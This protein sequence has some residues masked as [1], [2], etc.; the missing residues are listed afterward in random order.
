MQIHIDGVAIGDGCPPY[1][2]AEVSANHNQSLDRALEI[3]TKASQAGAS[4]IKIQTYT[5]DTITI[6]SDKEDFQ[7]RGG[8]WGGKTLY[9]LYGEAFTP[10]EWHPQLFTHARQLGITLFSTPFDRTAVDLLEDLNAPAYKIASFESTDI[11]LIQYVASTGKPMII[12]T[13]MA[14][15]EEIGEAV[16]AARGA[17]C[18][19]LVV[20]HCVS[21]YPAPAADYHLRTIADMRQKYQCLVGLSDHTLSNTTAIAAVSLGACFVEKHVTLDRTGGGPDDSFSLEPQQLH[22]LCA[23]CKEAWQ[24]LGNVNYAFKSSEQAN[25]KYRR[26]LYV[27]HDIKK[28][29]LFTMDN[30]RSIRPGFG[31]PPKYL[32]EVLGRR[33]KR[34]IERGTALK[35]DFIE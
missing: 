5:A 15:A 34:D 32:P 27:V 13:G 21:G 3:M 7:I 12:S 29:E 24:A 10:W 23:S 11:P 26:S 18:N 8:L 35:Q 30:V 31:M 1:V 14:N 4:A 28:G 20:L 19:Q 6:D 33:A 22:D 2:V 16:D 25:I 9:Q 17:G